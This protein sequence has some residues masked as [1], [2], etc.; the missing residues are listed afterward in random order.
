MCFEIDHDK[1]G[2]VAFGLFDFTIRVMSS[3]TQPVINFRVSKTTERKLFIA[4]IKGSFFYNKNFSLFHDKC[5]W[6]YDWNFKL[7]IIGQKDW[8][9]IWRNS[10]YA[11]F[12]VTSSCFIISGFTHSAFMF[13]ELNKRKTQ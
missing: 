13:G 4:F 2:E 12:L 5:D 8:K 11:S 10:R 3:V 6:I 9:L 1:L 7:G